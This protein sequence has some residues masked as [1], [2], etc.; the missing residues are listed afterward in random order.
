MYI[1]LPMRLREQ[2]LSHQLELDDMRLLRKR[3]EHTIYI[4]MY[5]YI[6]IYI[7]IYIHICIHQ[8]YTILY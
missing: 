2:R 7:Y 4:Y 1:R 8:F 6:Y 3:E 5:V